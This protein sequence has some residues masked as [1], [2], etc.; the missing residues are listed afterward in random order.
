MSH[1][2]WRSLE[3]QTLYWGGVSA[4]DAG[5]PP[6]VAWTHRYMSGRVLVPLAT[7]K[8]DDPNRS[9]KFAEVWRRWRE[10]MGPTPEARRAHRRVRLRYDFAGAPDADRTI[11]T[12]YAPIARHST[13]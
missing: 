13:R 1:E 3:A 11:R 10:D 9:R 4:D 7:F 2:W 12:R 5:L 6:R 8:D